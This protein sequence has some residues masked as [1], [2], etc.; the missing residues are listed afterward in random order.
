MTVLVLCGMS[1]SGKSTLAKKLSED[2]SGFEEIVS[3]TTRPPR[4]GE[5]DGVDYHFIDR[6]TFSKGIESGE[7]F[8][9]TEVHGN[10]YGSSISSVEDIMSRG[11]TPILVCDPVGAINLKAYKDSHPEFEFKTVFINLNPYDAAERCLQRLGNDLSKTPDNINEII[12]N[13]VKRMTKIFHPDEAEC[14]SL[15]RGFLSGTEKNVITKLSKAFQTQSQKMIRHG[16]PDCI[17]HSWSASY[18][19]DMLIRE[20]INAS[21]SQAAITRVIDLAK[22]RSARQEPSSTSIPDDDLAPTR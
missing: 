22:G 7:F 4:E 12:A 16:A 1:F 15:A 10:L 8:D 11:K 3:S 21:N 6:G 18:P 13:N 9:W 14:A 2:P 17:E 19:Y 20:G 5:Q